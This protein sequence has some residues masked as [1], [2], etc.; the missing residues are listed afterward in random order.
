MSTDT[1]RQLSFDVKP[2]ADLDGHRDG[3]LLMGS[4]KITGAMNVGRDL[5]AGD[6]VSIIVHDADGDV[7]AQATAE[8]D[9]PSFR[10]IRDKGTPIGTERAHKAR[11]E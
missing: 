5:N 4:L 8:V 9:A 6:T 1:D 10:V 11:I 3:D 2:H 7:L